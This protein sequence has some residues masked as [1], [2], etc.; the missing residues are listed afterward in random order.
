MEKE[1]LEMTGYDY[2]TIPSKNGNEMIIDYE[3]ENLCFKCTDYHKNNVFYILR[4]NQMYVPM[5]FM[6]KEIKKHDRFCYLNT[7]QFG[8]KFEWISDGE[9]PDI[10]NKMIIIE[11]F[12]GFR[13]QFIKNPYNNKEKRDCTVR[14]SLT[15]SNDLNIAN[16]FD[17]MV[18]GMINISAINESIIRK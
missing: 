6:F 17:K 4:N 10:Q 8:T 12:D 1:R 14:F 9:I 18:N 15:K 16:A 5:K 2:L 13:V 11:T 3:D 7:N